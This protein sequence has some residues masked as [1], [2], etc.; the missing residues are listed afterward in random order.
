MNSESKNYSVLVAG[1]GVMGR[2]IAQ[3]IAQSGHPVYLFDSDARATQSALVFI[4]QILDRKVAKEKITAEDAKLILDR[5]HLVSS[6]TDVSHAGLAIE[7]INE[8]LESKIKVLQKLEEVISTDSLLATNT[9]SLS[10]TAI[11]NG[12]KQPSRLVGMHF[13]NPAP[14]MKLVEIVSGMQTDADTATTAYELAKYWGKQPVHAQSTPGFIVNR[15]ARPFYAEALLL[16]QERSFSPLEIDRLI[17]AAGF[18]MGPCELM[19]LIGHDVNYQV[20]WSIFEANYFDRRFTPSLIQKS[21]IDAGFLGKKSG[22]GF[23]DYREPPDFS[24]PE[25]KRRQ[26]DRIPSWSHLQ[27]RGQ[28][29]IYEHIQLVLRRHEL[30]FDAIGGGIGCE[31]ESNGRK[32][33][34]TDGRFASQ[35]AK[36]VAVFDL[37]L[38]DLGHQSIGVTVSAG[39]DEDLLTDALDWLRLFGFNPQPVPDSAGL[40]VARTIA[41]LINEAADAVHQGVCDVKAA[42]IAVKLGLNYPA[43]PFEWLDELSVDYVCKLIGNLDQVYRGERYRVSPWL[44]QR[45]SPASSFQ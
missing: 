18:R 26:T 12:L 9:S 22:R 19:D 14:V 17:R 30:R 37:P 15:I 3:V 32:L 35:I 1:A 40:V 4:R 28:G 6:L 27:L 8:N 44:L 36:N 41:M 20:T 38:Q 13:F 10:I 2:G 7:A 5:I 42:D 25:Y 43:G 39:A 24:E 29:W 11:G 45:K 33:R 16:L 31:L 23:Y 34:L 21:L